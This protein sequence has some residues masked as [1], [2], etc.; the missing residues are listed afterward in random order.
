MRKRDAMVL[1][2][3]CGSVV[4]CAGAGRMHSKLL[5]CTTNLKM[6]A[7]ALPVY[8]DSYDGRMPGM[9]NTNSIRA[10][11]LLSAQDT[12]TNKQTWYNA[13]CLFK[14]GL[15]PDGRT[16]YCP[17][18]PGYMSEY[19]AYSNPAPWGSNLALQAPNRPGTGNVWLRAIMGNIYWPQNRRLATASDISS[20][21]TGAS[22]RYEAGYPL[23]AW[24]A[25]DV[26]PAK[27]IM[28]DARGQ[29][30]EGTTYQVNAVFSDGHV[31]YQ[32]VPVDAAT[33]KWM[34]PYQAQ[35]PVGATSSQWVETTMA[36]YMYRLQP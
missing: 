20:L 12:S 23:P 14:S 26:D 33:G 30:D 16:F 10:F 3:L 18:A 4:L 24:T 5:M 19:L 11:Y 8:C 32:P 1:L 34:Y 17:A 27:A 35:I 21:G 9:D 31:R 6:M 29:K 2:V 22:L 36:R 25:S 28:V 15:V 7:Q 13:G